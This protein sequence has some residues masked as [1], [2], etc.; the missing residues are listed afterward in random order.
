MEGRLDVIEADVTLAVRRRLEISGWRILAMD[1]PQSG[2][3]VLLRPQVSRGKS[4]GWVP[5]L[6]ASRGESLIWIESKPLFNA[7]DVEKLELVLSSCDMLSIVNSRFGLTCQEFFV[8]V[9]YACPFVHSS[10]T[11]MINICVCSNGDV[12]INDIG[13]QLGLFD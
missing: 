8:A 9:A 4:A 2:G 10:G 13:L 5:D 12:S 1:Y 11:G 3:G 7:T 6:L